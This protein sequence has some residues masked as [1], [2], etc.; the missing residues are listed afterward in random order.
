MLNAPVIIG[1]VAAPEPEPEPAPDAAKQENKRLK[2]ENWRL[3][4]VI[5][6]LRHASELQILATT[7]M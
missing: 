7:A 1:V 3:R 4:K 5:H 6:K 2:R